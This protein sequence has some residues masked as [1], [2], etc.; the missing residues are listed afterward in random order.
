[1]SSGK[2]K[3]FLTYFDYWKMSFCYML[4]Q[5][6]FSFSLMKQKWWRWVKIHMWASIQILWSPWHFPLCVGSSSLSHFSGMH[7]RQH[8]LLTFPSPS[9]CEFLKRKHVKL[10]GPVFTAL[11]HILTCS[12][13]KKDKSTLTS[14]DQL[15]TGYL[16]SFVSTASFECF[17]W[18]QQ[19][20]KIE[21]RPHKLD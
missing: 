2:N 7:T 14:A 5:C 20:L 11:C 19:M 16:F 18:L 6:W 17:G 9:G 3:V 13:S 12:F 4:C 1:M 15:I 8:D 10:Q 21:G